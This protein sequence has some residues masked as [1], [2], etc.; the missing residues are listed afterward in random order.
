MRFAVTAGV[1]LAVLVSGGA[2]RATT[3]KPPVVREVF[4]PLACPKHPISTIA[5]EGCTEKSILAT[6]RRINVLVRRIFF[7]LAPSAR[8]TFVRSERSW[9]SYRH[10][11]CVTAA[12]LYAGGS[13]QA[14]FFGSCVASRNAT[15]L[16]DLAS[17]QCDVLPQDKW[18]ESC[19]A[20][21][22]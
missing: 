4:T 21:Q 22:R 5:I 16:K 14:V 10:G 12:S 7:S 11:S 8:G 2:G 20:A 13:I 6:D 19:K 17:L 18:P 1:V 9:L 15:H 3:P